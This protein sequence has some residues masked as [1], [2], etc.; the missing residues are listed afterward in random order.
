MR[1]RD[2]L[3]ANRAGWNEAAPRHRARNLE[4]P[5]A[6]KAGYRPPVANFVILS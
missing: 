3:A 1:R 4:K 2:I 5:L 6:R